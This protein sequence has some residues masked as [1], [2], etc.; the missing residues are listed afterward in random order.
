[1]TFR[2]FGQREHKSERENTCNRRRFLH[3]LGTGVLVAGSPVAFAEPPPAAPMAN[4]ASVRGGRPQVI[5]EAALHE[6]GGIGRFVHKGQSV[7]IKPNMSWNRS[8]ALADTVHPEMVH[9]L[10]RLCLEAGAKRVT[11]FD[12]PLNRLK[13]CLQTTG[14]EEN[15]KD[16]RSKKLKLIR[17][18]DKNKT[19]Q[20]HTLEKSRW[21]K[22]WPIAKVALKSDVI[23]NLAQAK[24]HKVTGV[25][26]ALKNM[27]G[28]AGGNRGELHKNL[29]Q[30]IVDL[31]RNFPSTLT[32]ID[33]T[34]TRTQ[35]GPDG[36][37]ITGVR[38]TNTVIAADNPV[39]ADMC[40]CR[41][42]ELDWEE[43]G[44][45]RLA[46]EEGLGPKD[47]EKLEKVRIRL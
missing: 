44:H 30:N 4:L 19:F 12:H 32:V 27:M 18:I 38:W 45:I 29:N 3:L 24:H 9:A 40:A 7:L 47:F 36:K 6:I 10:A 5:L 26:L 28:I 35:N 39:A 20:D 25:S 1:M 34:R 46:M 16:I 17:R 11:V 21:L 22:T 41:L 8:P 23:I 31:N 14:I 37:D 33:A 42:F 13:H 2:E 15:L 43:V